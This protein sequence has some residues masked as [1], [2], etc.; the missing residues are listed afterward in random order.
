MLRVLPNGQPVGTIIQT[1]VDTL[2]ANYKQK[3]AIDSEQGRRYLKDLAYDQSIIQ[4]VEKIENSMLTEKDKDLILVNLLKRG[5]PRVTENEDGYLI[6]S[7]PR[8]S[9]DEPFGSAQPGEPSASTIPENA[10]SG[11]TTQPGPHSMPHAT[12]SSG[13]TLH[14]AFEQ[15]FWDGSTLSTLDAVQRVYTRAIFAPTSLLYSFLVIH[16]C[17]IYWFINWENVMDCQNRFNESR[18]K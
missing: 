12:D 8:P 14:S 7:S 1:K 11:G 2:L 3:R 10:P 15:H 9:S 18:A 16:T 13:S 17:S 4:S 5:S 6:I